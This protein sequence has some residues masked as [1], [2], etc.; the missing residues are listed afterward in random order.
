MRL[1]IALL[2]VIIPYCATEKLSNLVK[3]NSPINLPGPRC[4]ASLTRYTFNKETKEC[5][6]F[7]YDG[8][9][10]SPNNFKTIEECR[11]TCVAH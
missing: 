5:E 9:N 3:C 11:A 4:A 7:I 10:Q 1:F 8:C 6:E 2:C